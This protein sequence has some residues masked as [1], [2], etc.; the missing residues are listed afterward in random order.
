MAYPSISI[1]RTN[2][3]WLNIINNGSPMPPNP[4][5]TVGWRRTLQ[6]LFVQMIATTTYF[7]RLK[8]T[9]QGQIGG[10]FTFGDYDTTNC[11][12]TGDWVP[13]THQLW[14]EFNIDG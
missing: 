1:L 8:G 2:P 10:A 4:W 14:Y 6:L 9:P 12:T 7:C 11:A 5:F 3:P 13:L